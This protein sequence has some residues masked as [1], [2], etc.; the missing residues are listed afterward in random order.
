[1]VSSKLVV[2][3]CHHSWFPDFDNRYTF[4][5]GWGKKRVQVL[6][7]LV[8]LEVGSIFTGSNG[9]S[10]GLDG[11]KTVVVK[12]GG[13]RRGSSNESRLSSST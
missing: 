2:V 4:L 5:S 3:A 1:M 8:L 11:V 9:S 6:L 13:Y 12:K 7:F 10:G